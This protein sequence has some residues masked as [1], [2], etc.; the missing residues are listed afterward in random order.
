MKKTIAILLVLVIGM[1]GVFAAVNDASLHL[2]TEVHEFSQ[3]LITESKPVGGV[4][5]AEFGNT[6][7]ESSGSYTTTENRKGIDP[8]DATIQPVGFLHTR[9][10]RRGGY[11]IMVSATLLTS[12][13]GTTTENIGYDVY[14][15]EGQDL[16]KIYTAGGDAVLFVSE[17]PSSGMREQS[18]GISVQLETYGDNLS[19]GLYTGDITFEYIGK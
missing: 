18:N 4:T 19:A 12:T 16:T 2:K 17:S 11:E 3:M 7:V 13:E 5:W 8:Y 14:K 1:V 15:G 10:N 6:L 9:T